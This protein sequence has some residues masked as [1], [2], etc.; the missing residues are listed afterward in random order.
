MHREVED[1]PLFRPPAE[2]GSFLLRVAVG[3]PH[4]RCTFCGMY[5]GVAYRERTAAEVSADIAAAA[6]A[7]PGPRRVFLADGDA[8]HLP[9]ARL[10]AVLDEL[11]RAL[12]ALARV[13]AYANARSILAKSPAE[14]ADL[15]SRRLHTLYLG[16]ESGDAATLAAAAKP[17]TPEQMVEAAGRAHA[18]GLTLSVMVLLGLAG[19]AR[20]LAHA[21]ATAAA[22]NRMQPR[23]LSVLRAIPVP[24]TPFERAARAGRAEVLTEHGAVA[25]LRELVAGLELRGTVFRANHASNVV[26]V[27]ARFPRDRARLLAGLDALLAGGVLDRRSPGPLPLWL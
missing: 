10:A 20:S 3:C 9:A 2:A 4:N 13:N 26:P 19:R 16:L 22:L 14:L 25:E 1:A 6:R 8:L 17:E 21:R 5:R 12:P 23:L 27:E 18:A 15:R 11:A 24:G 7:A